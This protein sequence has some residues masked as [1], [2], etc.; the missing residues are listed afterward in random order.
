M[1]FW[2]TI[3]LLVSLGSF[4]AAAYVRDEP[5]TSDVVF[6]AISLFLLLSFPLAMVSIC[7]MYKDD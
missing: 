7:S 6:P 1:M 2:G 4:A 3:P 5:L